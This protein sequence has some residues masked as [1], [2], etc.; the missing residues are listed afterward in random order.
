[1]GAQHAH[2]PPPC[3]SQR[4][5]R[6]RGYHAG[7]P[8]PYLGDRVRP[9]QTALSVSFRQHPE[10][11]LDPIQTPRIDGY[12][13]MSPVPKIGFAGLSHLGIIYS[14]ASAARGFD[15]VAFDARPTIAEELA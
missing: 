4:Q 3:F 11:Y 5:A 13:G 10:R 12:R 9:L 1:M 7:V 2:C 14:T 8:R 6:R 15:V